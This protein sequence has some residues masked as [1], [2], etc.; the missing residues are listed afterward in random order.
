MQQ[1]S[2]AI[3]IMPVTNTTDVDD[4]ETPNNL[5]AFFIFATPFWWWLI[6]VILIRLYMVKTKL[7][8]NCTGLLGITFNTLPRLSLYDKSWKACLDSNVGSVVSA[9]GVS[10]SR[11]EVWLRSWLVAEYWIDAVAPQSNY[12]FGSQAMKRARRRQRGGQ[13]TQCNAPSSGAPITMVYR[14]M[15]KDVEPGSGS[16]SDTPVNLRHLALSTIVC[17]TLCASGFYLLNH[18]M[19]IAVFG[20][21]LFLT[22]TTFYGVFWNQML[23]DRAFDERISRD[24]DSIH[25][26]GNKYRREWPEHPKQETIDVILVRGKAAPGAALARIGWRRQS[27]IPRNQCRS[28]PYGFCISYLI[29]WCPAQVAS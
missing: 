9:A 6:A 5:I 18:T 11:S 15:V 2:V 3:P 17:Y 23:F 27:A 25:A 29:S 26:L 14:D 8:T 22:C 21:T 12:K 20:T 10:I 1:V 16:E 13:N 24:A 7:D 28:M 19:G 4:D